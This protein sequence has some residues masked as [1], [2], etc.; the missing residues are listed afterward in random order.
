MTAKQIEKT[1]K[2]DSEDISTD[3]FKSGQVNLNISKGSLKTGH[4]ESLIYRH[5]LQIYSKHFAEFTFIT[6]L[7]K[8]KFF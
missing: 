3:S 5:L 1:Q 8:Y 7:K 4:L 6:F 2:Q